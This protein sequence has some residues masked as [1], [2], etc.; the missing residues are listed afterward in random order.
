MLDLLRQA[1]PQLVLLTGEMNDPHG[2]HEQCALAFE[3]AAS[4][5]LQ[6]G[7]ASFARWNYRGAWDEFSIEEG[8][9]FSIFGREEM[10]SKIGLILDHVSQLD[11]LFPG[12]SDRRE[13]W[14]RARERNR[15]T[16]RELQKLGALPPSRSFE[17]LYAEVFRLA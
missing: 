15:A 12:G 13:F 1:R 8:N 14:E 17:P 5:Y 4:E 2:T 3:M 6:E 16:A 7:G 10:E 11:P 9:Y